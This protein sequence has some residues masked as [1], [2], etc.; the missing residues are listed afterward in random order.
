MSRIS[1][2]IKVFKE[3]DVYVALC[4]EL[5]V[6]SYGDDI[7][8]AKESLREA[9]EAFLEEC[10]EM[11]TLQEVL[12]DAGFVKE[13]ENWILEEPVIKEKIALSC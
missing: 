9:L 10:E 3:G 11:G 7:E 6:S 12:E 5:N 4:P 13:K 1:L 8:S 2:E